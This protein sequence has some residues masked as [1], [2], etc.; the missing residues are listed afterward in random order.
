M[1]PITDDFF[2]PSGFR[3]AVQGSQNHEPMYALRRTASH[4]IGANR[5]RPS[6]GCCSS[7]ADKP[8]FV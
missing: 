5:L 3:A 6:G 4:V 7:F 2:R 8:P 1:T